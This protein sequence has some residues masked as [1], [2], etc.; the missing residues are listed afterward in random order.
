[1]TWLVRLVRWSAVAL[2]SLFALV[3]FAAV[4]SVVPSWAL[5]PAVAV[6]AWLLVRL[7]R[8][9]RGVTS[10]AGQYRSLEVMPNA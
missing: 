3:Y 9:R 6:Y 4:A 5:L 10:L 2:L 7:I 1:M 8:R